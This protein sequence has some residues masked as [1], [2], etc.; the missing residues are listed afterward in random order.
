MPFLIR[1]EIYQQKQHSTKKETVSSMNG[2]LHWKKVI[3]D[4]LFHFPVLKYWFSYT[5]YWENNI[6]DTFFTLLGRL[7]NSSRPFF[8]YKTAA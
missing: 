8:I 5:R 6:S 3:I 4:C 1:A 2:N 7:E